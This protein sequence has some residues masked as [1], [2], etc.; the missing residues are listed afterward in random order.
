MKIKNLILNLIIV[1]IYSGNLFSQEIQEKNGSNGS[2]I[3]YMYIGGKP[4]MKALKVEKEVA[5]DWGVKIEVFFVDCG[6][7]YDYKY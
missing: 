7:T 3:W 1:S 5:K 4:D 2:L 6:G